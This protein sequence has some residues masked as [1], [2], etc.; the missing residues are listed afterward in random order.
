[1]TTTNVCP[2]YR[3]NNTVWV[4]IKLLSFLKKYMQPTVSW[5]QFT[6]NFTSGWTFSYEFLVTHVTLPVQYFVYMKQL[7]TTN[8][9]HKSIS[10]PQVD[11]PSSSALITLGMSSK[12]CLFCSQADHKDSPP[13]PLLPLYGE[14]FVIFLLCVWLQESLIFPYYCCS[15]K[16]YRIAV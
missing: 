11:K 3:I 5:P 1:M 16:N 2:R 9:R 6:T 10:F 15:V 13:P 14:L 4:H 7:N 12:S 8:G